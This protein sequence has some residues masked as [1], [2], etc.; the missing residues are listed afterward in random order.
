M[1]AGTDIFFGLGRFDALPEEIALMATH[2]MSPT[3]AL[4]AATRNGA[5]ALGMDQDFGTVEKGKK[6]DLLVVDGD[7]THDIAAL[8]N[9]RLVMQ[10]G[11][12]VGGRN[13]A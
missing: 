9:V 2:G 1:A 3:A 12:V 4:L 8:R 5:R 13:A 6:A 11:H 7:P 10:D